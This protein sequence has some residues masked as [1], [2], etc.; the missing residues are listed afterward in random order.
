MEVLEK[1]EVELEVGLVDDIVEKEDKGLDREEMP[2]HEG[3]ILDSPVSLMSTYELFDS[4]PST[5][6]Y[7]QAE[8]QVEIE[9]NI[10]IVQEEE[11]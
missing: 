8:E 3:E 2:V 9:G 7:F 1:M 10:M 11:V 4:D 5:D 6:P